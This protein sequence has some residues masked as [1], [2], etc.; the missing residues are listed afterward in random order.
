[1]SFSRDSRGGGPP[2]GG[3]K[4][5]GGE[6]MWDLDTP[7]GEAEAYLPPMDVYEKEDKVIIEIEL[8]GVNKDQI[9]VCV[10]RDMV[11]IE[12]VKRDLLLKGRQTKES[13]SYLRLERKYGRFYRGIKLPI[14]CN[15]REGEARY[16][17]GLLI[18]EF[19]KIKERRGQRHRIMVK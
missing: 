7:V 18:I 17:N 5:G 3:H 19:A 8:P 6:V 15:T 16:E 14:P 13:L 1:L 11:T 12:G 4:P 10:S 2:P 9:E